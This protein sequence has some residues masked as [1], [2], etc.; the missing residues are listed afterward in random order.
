[1][2]SVILAGQ[3]PA[4]AQRTG[5]YA[6]GASQHP[7]R[8]LP[9]LAA[10]LIRDHS[11]PGD[12]VF[13]PLA[14]TGTTL[15]E[16]THLGRN[17]LGVELENRW[18]DNARTSI[19]L[20]HRNGATG[21]ARLIQA[22][23]TR[24]PHGLARN[25]HGQVA[26]VLTS[27]PCGR[28]SHGRVEHRHRPLVRFDNT[29]GA[30]DR[31]NLA[32]RSRRGLIDGITAALAGCRALLRPGGIAAVVARSWRR[33]GLLVDLP[34]HIGNAAA[35]ADLQHIDRRVALRAVTG[36]EGLSPPTLVFPAHPPRAACRPIS[37]TQHDA[38]LVFRSSVR[39]S[40]SL[41]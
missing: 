24:L 30:Y 20:A 2:L 6:P 17:T 22:D 12:W 13:D 32:H 39:A 15:V 3:H 36:C 41:T 7:A 35:E 21:R 31:T 19:R 11:Q 28:T 34:G 4:G 10:Q 40:W 23:A 25:L 9:H 1:M 37:L 26:L 18:V 8:M 33:A 38:V 16:A 27:P 14:G 29:Y 5:R